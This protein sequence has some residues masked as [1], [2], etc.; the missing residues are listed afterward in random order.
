M[1]PHDFFDDDEEDELEELELDAE[2]GDGGIAE[3][4]LLVARIA[5]CLLKID[6]DMRKL[7][8]IINAEL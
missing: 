6:R 8:K 2:D 4:A 7:K 3:V 5:E 1:S